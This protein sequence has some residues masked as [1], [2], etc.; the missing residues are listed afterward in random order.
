MKQVESDIRA[1]MTKADQKQPK[2]PTIPTDD[3]LVLRAKLDVEEAME[4]CRAYGVTVTVNGV[5]ISH[6]NTEFVFK[7]EKEPSLVEIADAT[8]DQV[9]V[10]VGGAIA[11]GIKMERIWEIVQGSNMDKFGEGSYRR[12]DGKQMKPPG[13]KPPTEAIERELERQEKA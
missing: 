4:K 10:G 12:E 1:F 13:W 11:C 9:Y 6:E 2:V 5:D 3:V 7:A 8:A